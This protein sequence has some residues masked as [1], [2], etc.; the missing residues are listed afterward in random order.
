MRDVISR[1]I[2]ALW[3]NKSPKID[4][5][6][7]VQSLVELINDAAIVYDE[8]INRVLQANSAFLVLSAFASPEITNAPFEELFEGLE[9]EKVTLPEPQQAMLKIRNRP[10]LPVVL[11]STPIDPAGQWRLI[12]VVPKIENLYSGVKWME[13]VL[14]MIQ[15]LPAAIQTDGITGSLNRILNVAH[16]LFNTNLVSV[17]YAEPQVPELKKLVTLE[18]ITFFPETLPSTDLIRLGAATIW[19]PGKRVVTELHRAA[20]MVDLT[21]VASVPLGQEN[22]LSGL[23]VVGGIDSQPPPMLL[24]ILGV[25]G[26]YT[27][28]AFDAAIRSENIAVE[29]S[30]HGFQLAIQNAIYEYSDEGLLV[31]TPDLTISEINPSAEMMF[32]YT[33]SEVTGQ[34]VDNIL[35]SPDRVIPI[36]TSAKDGIIT[37]NLDMVTLHRRTGQTF[38]AKVKVIPIE[39]DGQ[40]IAINV[41]VNDVSEHEQ[42][43]AQTRQL[44]QRALL[45]EF[46]GVFA[47]EV[48]NPINNFSTGLQ[49]IARRLG[50]ENPNQELITRMENDVERISH[51]M[52]ALKNFAKPYEPEQIPVDIPQV[53]KRILDR[54]RPRM[55]RLRISHVY[56]VPED[57]PKINGDPRALEQVFTNLI[58]NALD[59]MRE[60]GGILSIRATVS[61]MAGNRPQLDIAISDNGPGIPDEIKDR[62]FEPFVTTKPMGTGLGLP[63]TKR[64]VT[65]HRGSI[66]VN[67]FPGGTVFHVYLPAIEENP[68][69]P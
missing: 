48:L 46:M 50:P 18:E 58:S 2:Q 23:L 38:P 62:I 37:P 43:R 8:Q 39:S 41:F 45:G 25:F 52:E 33:K 44:E 32:E 24:N 26:A 63:I 20:R 3:G 69:C 64:L 35:I 6:A 65:A 9:K 66:G 22:S 34:P 10:L 31:L 57:L 68:E 49:N 47:H 59:A 29:E 36:I 14:E 28:F 16:E 21:Y 51:Q 13:S 60:N 55:E 1:P 42:Y 12:R 61:E 56:Q 54:W 5:V 7:A 67:S 53:L 4:A 30:S 15:L 11:R 19:M 40:V 17:Y 27:K